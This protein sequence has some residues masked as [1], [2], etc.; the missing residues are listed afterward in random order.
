MGF[1]TIKKR[2]DVCN[3]ELI[4]RPFKM[5]KE[6]I[7]PVLTKYD[8]HVLEVLSSTKSKDYFPLNTHT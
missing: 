7:S 1:Y 4:I 6:S 8:D 2:S 3:Q 5:R